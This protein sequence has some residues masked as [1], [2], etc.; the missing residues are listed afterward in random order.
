MELTHRITSGIALLLVVALVVVVFRRF[1]RGHAARLGAVW[2][3][4][5]MLTEA[6]VGAGLVLFEL[7]ADNE[8]MARAL[9]MSVHLANTFL[10]L[11]ALSLTWFWSTGRPRPR[12]VLSTAP[13]RVLV[14][15][16]VALVVVG[17]SGAVSALGDTLFPAETLKEALRQDLSPTAHILVRLRKFHPL[18]AMAAGV[19]I[20]TLP[21]WIEQRWNLRGDRRLAG[22]LALLVLIQIAVGTAN[23][24]LLAPVWIQ[25]VHLLLADLL[26]IVLVLFSAS[27]LAG[28]RSRLRST[29]IL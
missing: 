5:F 20:L 1:P 28:E 6:G 25:L 8:S 4:V 2:S 22:S 26:W 15:A 27:L 24:A 13:G 7:V 11:A 3:L 23:V 16:H 12:D 21:R 29:P 14:L 9:F 18:L 17:M 10:L 19:G